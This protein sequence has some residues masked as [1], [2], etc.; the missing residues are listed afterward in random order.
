MTNPTHS[1]DAEL[2]EPVR[3]EAAVWLALL[4]SDTRSA[5]VEEGFRAWLATHPSHA[6]AF[7]RMTNTWET[8]GGVRRTAVDAITKRTQRSEDR[9]EPPPRRR[10][11]LA[12]AASLAG[13]ALIGLGALVLRP[14]STD[15]VIATALGERRSVQLADGSRLVL[16]TDTQVSVDFDTTE[17]SVILHRGQAR[18]YVAQDSQRPFIVHAGMKQIVARGTQFDV[19]WTDE[20]LAI[21]LFEGKVS[22]QTPLQPLLLDAGIPLE[23]GE[24]LYF[25]E[26]TL[27]VK[28]TPDLQREQAWVQGR[29][30]FDRTPLREVLAEMNRYARRPLKLGDP[31]LAELPISGTFSVEDS[32]AFARALGDVFALRLEQSDDSIVLKRSCREQACTA[33]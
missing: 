21:V 30:I 4:H 6:R 9:L 13:C 11:A 8:A 31:T 2:P 27:A 18:F 3:A 33:D 15:Q 5:E 17:R 28:S 20:R 1:V 23:P 29:A 25:A 7:E 24:R 14:T 22:V 16:N 10:I 12:V 26:P 32:E 19:R